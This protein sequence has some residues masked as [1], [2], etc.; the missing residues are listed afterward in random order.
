MANSQSPSRS[1]EK[2]PGLCIII[3]SPSAVRGTI[4]IREIIVQILSALWANLCRDKKRHKIYPPSKVE[5]GRIFVMA[6][7]AFDI[8]KAE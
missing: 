6:R 2:L 4:I 1:K 5:T 3:K 7:A 8:K